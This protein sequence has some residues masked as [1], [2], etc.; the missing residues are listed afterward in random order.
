MTTTH[1]SIYGLAPDPKEVDG[2]GLLWEANGVS[3]IANA[4]HFARLS[5]SPTAISVFLS[6]EQSGRVE[7]ALSGGQVRAFEN[8]DLS[9]QRLDGDVERAE[10][11]RRGGDQGLR[12]AKPTPWATRGKDWRRAVQKT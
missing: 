4:V 7:V 1:F 12:C 10:R 6:G 3:L 11:A 2:R 5:V 9:C 8:P